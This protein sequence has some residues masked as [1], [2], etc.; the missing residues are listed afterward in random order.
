M[1]VALPLFRGPAPDRFVLFTEPERPWAFQSTRYI[2][3]RKKRIEPSG[4]ASCR[5]VLYLVEACREKVETASPDTSAC[6]PGPR[7]ERPAGLQD[8]LVEPWLPGQSPLWTAV[9]RG[10]RYRT[11]PGAAKATPPAGVL[12]Y[13]WVAVDG[14]S[15]ARDERSV[16]I[17]S[18]ARFL[19]SSREAKGRTQD[20]QILRLTGCDGRVFHSCLRCRCAEGE[21]MIRELIEAGGPG[22]LIPIALAGGAMYVINWLLGFEHR[23]SERRRQFLELWTKRS[24]TD[25]LWSQVALRHLTGEYLPQTLVDV[26]MTQSDKAIALTELANVWD[27]LAI[28]ETQPPQLHWRR[29]WYESKGR[30]RLTRL[31]FNLGYFVVAWIA[32]W[33]L[34]E[35]AQSDHAAHMDVGNSRLSRCIDGVPATGS[36]PPPQG[37]VASGTTV[38]PAL[39]RVAQSPSHDQSGGG[40]DAHS[41]SP[42]VA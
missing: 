32:A 9:G 10:G 15:G 41:R 37:G 16:R 27:Y 35:A 26:V 7:R 19:P 4:A 11:S 14:L 22:A 39:E 40:A 29:R 20:S 38:D 31:A 33:L 23:R 12:A 34:L 13:F 1:T 8:Q 30:R 28:S 25:E 3:E 21:R 24:E 36:R 5:V 6:H 42:A 18:W 17:P 2:N